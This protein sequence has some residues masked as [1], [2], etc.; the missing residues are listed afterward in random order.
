VL[1]HVQNN[2]GLVFEPGG[3]HRPLRTVYA[4]TMLARA[5]DP[6]DDPITDRPAR[7]TEP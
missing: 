3:A 2:D 4:M 7:S 1:D 5:N 6:G